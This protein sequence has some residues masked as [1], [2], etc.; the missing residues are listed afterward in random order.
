MASNDTTIDRSYVD[1]FSVKEF[2]K[3][4]LIDKYFPDIDV[5]LRTVGMVGFTTEQVSNI[6]EDI[7]NTATV[8]FRETFPNRAQ[9][10]ESIYSHAAIFQ[11]SNVF[12]SAASCKFLLVLEED[13]IIENMADSF[14]KDTGIYTFYIDKNTI[15]NVEDMPY[16]L[17]YD[18]ELRIVRKKNKDN[19]D[20]YIFAASYV[21]PDNF[22]NTLADDN[23]NSDPYIKIKRSADGYIALEI[24][25]H[26]CTRSV[27]YEDIISSG[28]INY[29]VIDVPFEGNLA[30]FDIRYK[31]STDTDDDYKQ[32]KT[33]VVYSQ[34]IEE[35]F[36]Y[37]QM[38]DE[39]TLRITFNTK[40]EYFTPDYGSTLEITLY[41]TLGEDGNFDVYTGTDIS[42]TSS[43]ENYQYSTPY[44]TAAKP[45]T[46]SSGG[47]EQMSMDGLQSLAVMSYRTATA[48]TTDADLSEYFSNYKYLYGN[49]DI[50]FIKKRNDIYERIYSAFIIMKNENYIYNTNTLSLALNLS[51]MENPETSIYMIHPGTLFTASSTD[52]GYADFFRDTE[53]TAQNTSWYNEYLKAVEKGEV[54]FVDDSVDHNDL[55]DY[56]KDRRASFAEYKKRKGYDDKVF[57]F[58]YDTPTKERILRNYDDPHHEANNHFL[59][60]NPFLIRFKKNP[61]LVSMYMTY[62]NQASTLDFS[63]KYDDSYVQF[64]LYQLKV[65]REFSKEKKYTLSVQLMPSTS[66]SEDYPI[67]NSSITTVDGY[68]EVDYVLNDKYNTFNND[69]RVFVVINDGVKDVC[70]I[71][72]YPTDYDIEN[73]NFT[74]TAEFFTDDHITTDGRLRVLSGTIYKPTKYE[75]CLSTS[76]HALRVVDDS[77]PSDEFDSKTMIKISDVI[78]D[79]PDIKVGTEEDKYEYAQIAL[80]NDYYQ[81]SDDDYTIYHH[82]DANGVIEKDIN[83]DIV[84]YPVDYI[85][86]EVNA[87]N[88]R[89]WCQV[90]NMT[91]SSEILIP[92]TDVKCLVYTTYRRKYDPDTLKLEVIDPDNDALYDDEKD[93]DV[94]VINNICPDKSLGANSY[95][96]TLDSYF[97]TNEY[98]SA[99]DPITFL[100]PLNNVRSNLIFKDYTLTENY[101]DDNGN[102]S[103]RYVYDILDAEISSIPFIRWSTALDEDSLS[104]FMNSFLAQYNNLIDII[105]TK[106]RNETSIDVKFYNT[107]G[108]SKNFIIGEEDERMDT[109]NLS[110]SFDV[111]FTPGT[112]L[113]SVVPD[114]KEYIKTEIETINSDGLNNLYISNLMRKIELQFV[115]VDHIRFNYIN[116]YDPKYQAVKNY[117]T[118]L[119]ELTVSERRDYV[120]EFLV[121]DT[122]DITI[123]EY[124]SS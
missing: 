80:A 49:S 24:I 9:I 58:D 91:S 1:N 14:D 27:V 89:R 71:E 88:L 113:I 32:L 109:V 83:N 107:Y 104:Y 54:L 45:M 85:T 118:D 79:I 99:S 17:D 92:M 73:E 25:C 78:S 12:S 102:E 41:T 111:W 94:R 86:Q 123:N 64:I 82:Y 28:T 21:I 57:V 26:Q 69:L 44:I 53:L 110:L 87:G 100:K 19:T 93:R 55:P 66:I 37:Y 61:N 115:Y 77:T 114:V 112:D 2:T 76:V 23:T 59:Y 84:E 4:N 47:S 65:K 124:F 36:C 18:I 39:N 121:V 20:D 103:F 42:V 38:A 97:I 68:E 70:Y 3:E 43:D 105:N 31:T 74:F 81:V 48:L 95:D 75:K 101:T 120:P 6:S 34:P 13:A 29:P 46:S 30:G 108:R 22:K 96:T 63:Y 119:S 11:L 98:Q 35:K 90:V 40:D 122:E 60:I 116:E 56:L 117:V 33:L 8:L 72:M 16:I 50:M 106:L 7:F 67:I 51:D 5:S 15:I 52:Y 62:I 10:P